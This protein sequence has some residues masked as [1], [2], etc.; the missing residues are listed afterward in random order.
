MT[1]GEVRD[2]YTRLLGAWN[3]R[4]AGTFAALFG[5]DGA[6]IGFDGSQ[7]AGPEIRDHLQ[8]VFAG[9]PTAAYVA[10]VR[11]VRSLAPGVALLR[12]A[13]GMVP[14]GGHDL[15]PAVNTLQ[16]MLATRTGG[17]WRIVLF[18][19]TPAQFHGRPE[20]TE[21]HL[22]DLRPVVSAGQTVA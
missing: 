19:N 4:D 2:L 9:H 22:A 11:E 10:R 14:P 17:E 15:N 16:T 12:A 5:D 20:L 21:Q 18:Q 6:M 7:A 3:E 13:A 8:A 1:D